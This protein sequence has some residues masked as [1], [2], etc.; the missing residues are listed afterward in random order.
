MRSH[1]SRYTF[2]GTQLA[3]TQRCGLYYAKVQH[4]ERLSVHSSTPK[5][6]RAAKGVFVSPTVTP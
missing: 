3:C 6:K 1:A 5:A 4:G 2:F